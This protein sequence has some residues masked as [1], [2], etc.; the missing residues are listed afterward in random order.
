MS[1]LYE[2]FIAKQ[3]LNKRRLL[4]A[5]QEEHRIKSLTDDE[6]QKILDEPTEEENI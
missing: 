5:Q 6:L 2:K 4:K 3:E 1:T